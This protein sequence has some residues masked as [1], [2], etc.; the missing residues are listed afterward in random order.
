MSRTPRW[1]FDPD[2]VAALVGPR[3]KAIVPLYLGGVT[4]RVKDLYA[5]AE[6]HHL[7]I[8]EDATHAFGTRV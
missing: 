4:G 6:R 8:V 5:L 7:R 1:G 3:T 2:T